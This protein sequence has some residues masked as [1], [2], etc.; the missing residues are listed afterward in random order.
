[1]T[2][3]E[4]VKALYDDVMASYEEIQKK[5][6]SKLESYL[7]KNDKEPLTFQTKQEFLK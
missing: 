1:M 6:V 4:A 7:E 2:N 3:Y 5:Q